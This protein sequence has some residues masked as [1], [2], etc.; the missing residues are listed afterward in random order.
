MPTYLPTEGVFIYK[1]KKT[2]PK[3]KVF[4]Y[5]KEVKKNYLI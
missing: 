1:K 5:G 2:E 3:N 4:F